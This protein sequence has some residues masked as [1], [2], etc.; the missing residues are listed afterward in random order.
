MMARSWYGC[1][2]VAA[3]CVS[4][5][6]RSSLAQQRGAPPAAEAPPTAAA[7]EARIETALGEV[8]SLEFTESPLSEIV[9]FLKERHK[10]AIQL[11]TAALD[12][13]GVTTDTPVTIDVEGVT[14]RSALNLMLKNIEL[15]YC[16]QDG[17]LLITTPEEVDSRLVREVYDARHFIYVTVGFGKRSRDADGLV[18]LVVTHVQPTTWTDVGGMGAIQILDEGMIVAQSWSI[19]QEVGQFMQSLETAYAN[20]R[21][22][23]FQS[24]I[25][26]GTNETSSTKAVRRALAEATSLQ[27]T[28]SPLSDI[29]AYLK[30]SHKLPVLLDTASL[31]SA[32][33]T[34]DSPVTIDV[35]GV[36]LTNA[37]NLMLKSIE[38]TYVVRDEVLLITTPEEV[39]S[40]LI[41]RI[42]PVKD[43]V[44][45][46]ERAAGLQAKKGQIASGVVTTATAVAGTTSFLG[47]PESIAGN[48]SPR[49]DE[50]PADDASKKET[51]KSRG[52]ANGKPTAGGG[53]FPPTPTEEIVETVT[54]TVESTTWVDVGGTGSISY[55]PEFQGLVISQTE[56]VHAKIDDLFARLRNVSAAQKASPE[57]QPLGDAAVELSLRPYELTLSN[58]DRVK[59]VQVVAQLLQRVVEPTSWQ[60][61]DGRN[62][63]Q[64][65]DNVLMIQTTNAIH[66]QIEALLQQLE[67]KRPGGI[68]QGGGFSGGAPAESKPVPKPPVSEAK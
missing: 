39:D 28:E 21:Q 29:V 20:H 35:E 41:T 15:T 34:H 67:I 56:A 22:G 8:T 4:T 10:L 27:F 64:V 47:S 65:V 7:L 37:L 16:L 6:G 50:R 55:A 5:A 46:E 32:G 36:P 24:P 9:E 57:D 63:V 52:G 49:T 30:E 44:E 33:V 48:K 40:Q 53:Y 61:K 14:L 54:S 38:L 19:Q 58:G 12:T 26:V 59:D 66:D 42:Y 3:I 1:A 51:P 13:A 11:D 17:V 18:E 45:A 23:K 25:D 43:L 31:D 60:R 62:F 2:L 68:A